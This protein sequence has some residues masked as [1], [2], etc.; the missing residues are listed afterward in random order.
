MGEVDSEVRYRE[1]RG[2]DPDSA[3]GLNALLARLSDESWRV[4]RMAVDRLAAAREPARVIPVL[5]DALGAGDDAGRRNAAVEALVRVGPAAVEPLC[6]RLG[7]ADGDVRKFA[8]DVLGEIGDRRAL[9]ALE[10][11]LG[12]ADRNVRGAAAEALG[13]IGGPGAAAGLEAALAHD[14]QL[15][16]LSALDALARAGHTPPISVLAPLA[17]DRFLRRPLYRL[18][19][20][21]SDPIA[22]ELLLAGL[23]ESARGTREAAL[24]AM[25]RQRALRGEDGWPALGRRIH[26]AAR[27]A[28]EVAQGARAALEA[29]D[30]EVVRGAVWVLAMAQQ[31]A[32][33]AE[34]ARAGA[35][36]RLRESCVDAL[37]TLGPA[38]GPPL[39]AAMASLSP[40]GR[41]T[42]VRALARLREQSALNPL[43]ALATE[44]APDERRLAVEAL[45]ELGDPGAV[46]LLAHLVDDADVAPAAARALG[47]IGRR[48]RRAVRAEVLRRLTDRPAPGLLRVLG[49]VAEPGDL[50]AVRACARHADAAVRVAAVEALAAMRDAAAAD[51]VA[52]ALADE[53]PLVRA[54]AARSLAA[55]DSP[56]ARSSLVAALRDED[57]GVAA[58]AAAA[59]AALGAAEGA[60][61]LRRLLDRGRVESAGPAVLPVL[62]A[63]RALTRLGAMDLSA[64]EAAIGHPDPDVVKEA[65]A[66][67]PAVAGAARAVLAAAENPRWDVRAAAARAFQA[68]GD[69][70]ALP[71]IRALAARERDATAARAFAEAV[72]A[73]SARPK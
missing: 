65:L 27:G 7:D 47:A 5:I 17:Q 66:A 69:T 22:L 4:R 31:A 71:A 58:A 64:L 11:A 44:G 18:L 16:R 46:A 70:T 9:I 1:V 29:E 67:A 20:G 50:A 36:D 10:G 23:R 6:Q 54:A 37:A 26:D 12:D 53:D 21:L 2:L 14:D 48:D 34:I 51:T 63:V 45:G 38:A 13:K 40:G 55:F 42:A 15:L 32:A 62:A 49:E 39:V 8:A 28:P 19:G 41:A 3:E 52:Y 61:E 72:A 33:A 24:A 25:A 56:G 57:P 73:L 43:S 30:P 68:A 59:L 60:Q 35:D